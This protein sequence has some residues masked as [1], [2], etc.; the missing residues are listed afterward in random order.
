MT[1][2]ALMGQAA[3]LAG[4][5]V[6]GC[7]TD[8]QASFSPGIFPAPAPVP[9]FAATSAGGAQGIVIARDDV[10]T[11]L[12]A[13]HNRYRTEAGVPLLT[14][15]ADLATGAARYGPALAAR[16]KLAHSPRADRPG[17]GENL[18]M[19]TTGAFTPEAMVN[20]WGSERAMYRDGVFPQVS[21]TGN[22]LDV[23][24]YT[25][26]IWRTTTKVGCAV[27]RAPR[28]DYLI[29]RYSPSGNRDGQRAR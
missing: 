9:G 6:A 1:S 25:Q 28:F 29:C 18:W 7:T 24:H 13:A 5:V 14:W 19:G 20:A 27:H 17:I 2:F 11:R 8:G 16:G 12:L 3:V 26:M 23:S 22:W 4:L 15:D 10:A 21:S